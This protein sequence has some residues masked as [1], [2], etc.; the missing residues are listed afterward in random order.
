M[1]N[2]EFPDGS[3][4]LRA[5]IDMTSPNM[6]LRDP[7]LYRIKRMSHYRTGDKWCIYPMYDFAHGQSDYIEGITHSLCTL[8]FEVHRALYDW[9]LDHIIDTPYRPRQIEFARLNL[10]YTVMSKRKLL[11][12]VNGKYVS[13]WDDPRLPTISGMRRRGDTPE[14]IRNFAERVGVA[15]RENIIDLALLEFSV[16]EDLNKKAFRKMAVLHPL[17]VAITNYPQGQTEYLDALNNP[18]NE[19]EGHRKIPFSKEL[20]IEKEDFSENPPDGYFRLAPGREVRLKYAYIIKCEGVVKDPATGEVSELLCTYDPETRS[21]M[22]TEK[23]VKST[24]QWVEKKEA[25][26]TEVRLY[27]RLFISEDPAGARDINF[28]DL[29]N[30]DSLKV[31]YP[32]YIEPSIRSCRVLDKLQFERTGYFCVDP[33]TNG[34]RMVFNRTVTLK[35]SWLKVKNKS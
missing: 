27:D 8:E 33:D 31:I 12:L 5:R 28:F 14:A 11:E 1:K 24:I 20:Y 34:E 18:E 6:H 16:R 7:A 29:I 3:R 22:K 9:L 17:K 4:V 26:K 35:D 30:P 25:V 23:K 2:G 21:G 19:S 32:A 10:S 13:G 15:R